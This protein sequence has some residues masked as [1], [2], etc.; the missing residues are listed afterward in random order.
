M[1][2]LDDAHDILI[3]M[4]NGLPEQFHV[5]SYHGAS[6][7]IITYKA[8]HH[9][10]PACEKYVRMTNGRCGD[11]DYCPTCKTDNHDNDSAHLEKLAQAWLDQYT[12]VK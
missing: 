3:Q 8:L 10:C 9:W 5:E 4:V 2:A 7:Q 1:T 6:G 12:E 11:A